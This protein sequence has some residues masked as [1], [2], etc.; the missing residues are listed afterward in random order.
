M[1]PF[2][3]GSLLREDFPSRSPSPDGERG[4]SIEDDTADYGDRRHA[5]DSTSNLPFEEQA[6]IRELRLSRTNV[7]GESSSPPAAAASSSK[8][9]GL[10]GL[11]SMMARMFGGSSAGATPKSS[12]SSASAAADDADAA[13]GGGAADRSSFI[14][15]M[16]RIA[17][18]RAEHIYDAPFANLAQS[19]LRKRHKGLNAEICS[20]DWLSGDGE[21]DFEDKALRMKVRSL[22]KSFFEGVF[23]PSVC[24]CFQCFCGFLR[25]LAPSLQRAVSRAV[26][27]PSG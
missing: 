20:L 24:R 22:F 21:T 1:N 10:F 15:A 6:T 5:V 16:E 12:G 27:A 11:R 14:A 13:G 2:G 7:Q 25:A 19:L 9:A 17:K 3:R 26:A 23:A 4:S 18:A 8:H